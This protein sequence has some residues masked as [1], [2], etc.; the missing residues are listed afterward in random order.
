MGIDWNIVLFSAINFIVVVVIVR[1]LL[2]K[3]VLKIIEKRKQAIQENLDYAE[4]ARAEAEQKAALAR[5]Q[6]EKSRHAA[7]L[8]ITKAHKDAEKQRDNMYKEAHSM[9]QQLLERAEYDI[10]LER[11]RSLIKQQHR[12]TDLATDLATKLM[13][14][15]DVSSDSS[16]REN[17]S[18]NKQQLSATQKRMIEQF[19][20]ELN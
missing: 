18:D 2:F 7:E 19:L 17:P 15:E 10:R 14:A 8:I 12:I 3:P 20:E 16:E 13:S 6:L 11:Q 5:E 4:K 9:T 1:F